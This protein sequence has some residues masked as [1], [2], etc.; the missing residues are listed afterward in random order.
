LI[1]KKYGRPLSQWQ[2]LVRQHYLAKHLE[3]VTMLKSD[4]GMGHGQANARVV[5]T[6]AQ[7]ER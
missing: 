7:D 3:L 6:L 1:E 2:A 4:Q 5:H